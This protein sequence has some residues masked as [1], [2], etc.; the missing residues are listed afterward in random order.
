M[1]EKLQKSLP[2][3]RPANA[4]IDIDLAS[5]PGTYTDPAYGK[6]T[7]CDLH[8]KSSTC[9]KT[10][11]GNPFPTQPANVP[12]F[13]AYFPEFWSDYL[14]FSHRNGST[15]TV[16]ASATY[17]ETNVTVTSPHESF[18]A[19]FDGEGMAWTRGAW[20]AGAGVEEKSLANG[21]EEGAEVWFKKE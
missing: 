9:R 15:F 12:T 8:G 18:D 4:T 14:L 17:A 19:V 11:A 3:L 10:L 21:L 16:T 7:I 5:I 20:G 6:V 13:I 2:P 1:I